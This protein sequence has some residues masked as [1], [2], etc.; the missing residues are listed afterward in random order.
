MK[1]SLFFVCIATL[2]LSAC[3]KAETVVTEQPQEIGFKAIS[4]NA[5]KAD[6]QL[7]GTVL[8]TTYSIYASATQKNPAGVIENAAFFVDQRFWTDND[9]VTASSQYRAWGTDA[10]APIY[11]PVGG[12]SIDFLAYAMPTKKHVVPGTSVENGAPVA[13]YEKQATDAASEVAFKDW[14]TYANQVDLLYAANNAAKSSTSGAENYVKLS[15]KHAQALLVFQAKVNTANAVTINS[16]TINGLKVKGTFTVDNSRNDLVASWSNLEAVTGENV[17]AAG[18]DPDDDNLKEAI[19]AT[20]G[21]AQIGSTLLIPEQPRLNFTIN[22]TMGGKDMNYTYN[23]ARGTW[24]MGKK[25]IY[26]LDMTLSEIILTEDVQ[27]FV[28]AAVPE[29]P[30]N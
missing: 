13:A 18:A 25:Y 23:E 15:F 8:N 29:I 26:K 9:P 6:A 1:K 30:L 7:E 20:T 4:S 2:G 24:E 11:W 16:I 17:I 21:Y 27:D 10:A 5:T 3:Y 19:A 22:Y 14:D 28:D 12:V